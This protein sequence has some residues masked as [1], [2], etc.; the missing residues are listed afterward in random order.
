MMMMMIV[1]MAVVA[2]DGGQYMRNLFS[3]E[4]VEFTSNLNDHECTEVVRCCDEVM[5]V[6]C[7]LVWSGMCLLCVQREESSLCLSEWN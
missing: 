2:L 6:Y 5:F 1:M 7:L 4:L 3:A